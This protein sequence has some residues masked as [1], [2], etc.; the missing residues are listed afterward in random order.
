MIDNKNIHNTAMDCFPKLKNSDAEKLNLRSI[1]E[2]KYFIEFTLGPVLVTVVMG[3]CCL[4]T[5]DSLPSNL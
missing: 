3:G 1:S 5:N 2:G 4:E